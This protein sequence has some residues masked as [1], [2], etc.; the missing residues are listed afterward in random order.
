MR[1]GRRKRRSSAGGGAGVGL[2]F[3]VALGEPWRVAALDAWRSGDWRQLD[4]LVTD[5]P[6]PVTRGDMISLARSLDV[7]VEPEWIR[8]W[9]A[10]QPHSAV[11]RAARGALLTG[12]AW[13]IRGGGRADTVGEDAFEAFHAHLRVADTELMWGARLDPD[14]VLVWTASLVTS[15]GLSVALEETWDR[16]RHVERL[17][18]NSFEAAGLMTQNLAP[19]WHGTED[20]LRDFAMGLSASAPVG[21][22]IHSVVAKYH[23]EMMVSDEHWAPN[24]WG[25]HDIVAA[26]GRSR[27]LDPG[28]R[29]DPVGLQARNDFAMALH[30]FG[31]HRAGELLAILGW[32]TARLTEGPWYYLGDPAEVIW[33]VGR[34]YGVW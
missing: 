11:A 32:N 1:E 33:S 23:T 18:P 8:E 7:A 17:L 16:Y 21:D 28:H 34:R 9:V 29:L 3:D 10:E 6:D 14:E 19:K 4:R 12:V 26:L 2:Q 31:D 25:A 27:L 20:Q 22:P 24:Q 15:L 13:E 5:A 30:L